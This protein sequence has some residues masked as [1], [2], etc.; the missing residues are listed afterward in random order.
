[1]VVSFQKTNA[2]VTQTGEAQTVV[3]T[4]SVTVG[5]DTKT[6]DFTVVVEAAATEPIF[7]FGANGEASH[8]D[9]ST[10][11]EGVSYEAAGYTLTLTGLSKVNAGA[12][13]ATGNSALKLG[14]SSAVGTFSFTVA[15]DVTSVK[16]YVAGYKANTA[17]VSINGGEAQTISTLSNNG[18]YTCITVDV[19]TNKTVSFTTVSGGYRAMIDTIEFIVE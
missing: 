13:D 4:A 3:L 18:E 14:T 6:K 7:T 19:S 5:S 17:K 8:K 11:S 2:T 1:M 12:Y 15:N 10:A 9:G 16:I